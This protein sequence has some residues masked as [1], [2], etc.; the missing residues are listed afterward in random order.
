MKATTLPCVEVTLRF[1]SDTSDFSNNRSSC[2]QT[3][4][5]NSNGESYVVSIEWKVEK[6]IQSQKSSNEIWLLPHQISHI[7]AE[8]VGNHKCWQIQNDSGLKTFFEFHPSTVRNFHACHPDLLYEETEPLRQMYLIYLETLDSTLTRWRRDESICKLL[9]CLVLYGRLDFFCWLRKYSRILEPL[10]GFQERDD[11]YGL[12]LEQSH[13]LLVLE[14]EKP[15]YENSNFIQAVEQMDAQ[16][17][18]ECASL[19][20]LRDLADTLVHNLGGSPRKEKQL[21]RKK[22]STKAK[23]FTIGCRRAKLLIN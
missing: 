23:K 8:Y 13:C 12:I 19:Q 7:F 18:F 22:K 1:S 16:G 3:E 2:F 5:E 21:W 20:R 4:V 10:E 15:V 6:K 17:A 9:F 14:N 11:I